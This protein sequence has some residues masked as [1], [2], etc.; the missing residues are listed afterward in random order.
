MV[1]D[2]R[3]GPARLI[4][5]DAHN[6]DHRRPKKEAKARASW[7][8]RV[9]KDISLAKTAIGNCI[10]YRVEDKTEE[11]PMG[12]RSPQRSSTRTTSTHSRAAQCNPQAQ[13]GV[14]SLNW[15]EARAALGMDDTSFSFN[16]NGWAVR[17]E[18]EA[19]RG[20]GGQ[21]AT[22]SAPFFPST[23]CWT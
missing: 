8:A 1:I 11:R 15:D 3:E 6:Q 7:E 5:K 19:V 10:G 12:R 2:G 17:S 16:K 14:K 23:A 21:S 4:F 18:T 9:P 20:P 22:T 13:G